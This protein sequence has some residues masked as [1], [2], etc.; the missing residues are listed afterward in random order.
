MAA[1]GGN[2]ERAPALELTVDVSEIG[3]VADS[4]ICG[5]AAWRRKQRRDAIE[6]AACRV[7]RP[8]GVAIEGADERGLELAA[9]RAEPGAGSGRARAR[10]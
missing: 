6:V 4:R 10:R 1:A 9:R 7:E 5:C 8:G 2:F 3:V